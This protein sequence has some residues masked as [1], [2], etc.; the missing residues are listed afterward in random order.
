[1]TFMGMVQDI[2]R[3]FKDIQISGTLNQVSKKGEISFKL[4]LY[5]YVIPEERHQTGQEK[6]NF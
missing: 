1:M 4:F 6:H 5:F 2:Y 3:L